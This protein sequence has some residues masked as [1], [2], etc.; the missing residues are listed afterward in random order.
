MVYINVHLDHGPGYGCT[1]IWT[2]KLKPATG[3]RVIHAQLD[4]DLRKFRQMFVDL[5]KR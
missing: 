4:L 5:M 3:D 1:L 2:E